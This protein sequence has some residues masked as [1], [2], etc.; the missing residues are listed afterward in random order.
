[1]F[2]IIIFIYDSNY[3]YIYIYIDQKLTS[4]EISR[5]YSMNRKCGS[6]QTNFVRTL[7]FNEKFT[8][9]NQENN[10]SVRIEKD[11]NKKVLRTRLKMSSEVIFW[12][13]TIYQTLNSN[14]K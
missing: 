4:L 11:T 1:M 9:L 14:I 13:Y 8:I 7:M 2:N 5:R 10:L 6:K 3:K 12:I